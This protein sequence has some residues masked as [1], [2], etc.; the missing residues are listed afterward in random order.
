MW[1]GGGPDQH[2]FWINAAEIANNQLG[3]E[4]DTLEAISLT[5]TGP[6]E[7]AESL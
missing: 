1:R 4:S 7:G 6:W 3:A 5:T 2:G